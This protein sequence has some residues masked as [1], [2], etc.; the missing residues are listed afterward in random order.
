MNNTIHETQED[1]MN[2]VEIDDL[3]KIINR[4]NKQSNDRKITIQADTFNAIYRALKFKDTEYGKRTKGIAQ[5]LLRASE[6]YEC[7]EK[8]ELNTLN[9]ILERIK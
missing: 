4:T 7:F 5:G 1:V 9:K 8:Q 2:W 6:I 3:K